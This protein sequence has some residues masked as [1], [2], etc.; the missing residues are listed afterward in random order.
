MNA[1]LPLS[2]TQKT[3]AELAEPFRL[4]RLDL[5]D[6]NLF[7]AHDVNLFRAGRGRTFSPR[8]DGCRVSGG[9]SGT[10]LR[11]GAGTDTTHTETHHA[12][13]QMNCEPLRPIN[14]SV[15][16]KIELTIL[17]FIATQIQDILG[18][19][20]ITVLIQ[21][22]MNPVLHSIKGYSGSCFKS[23]LYT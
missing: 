19:A 7:R 18:N 9:I 3:A 12:L 5:H 23:T 15:L 11:N 1:C 17:T 10:A 6:V 4:H 2:T 8:N 14:Q 13:S 20:R 22:H 16:I 21:V